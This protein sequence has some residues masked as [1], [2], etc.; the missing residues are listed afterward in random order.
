[1][2]PIQD[3]HVF[4]SPWGSISIQLTIATMKPLEYDHSDQSKQEFSKPC[5]LRQQQ[6]QRL[7]LQSI[8]RCRRCTGPENFDQILL[9]DERFDQIVLWA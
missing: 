9:W 5:I 6:P 7:S 3:I 2:V 8:R 1:M 4:L